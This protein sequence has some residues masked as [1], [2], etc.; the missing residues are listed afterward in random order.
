MKTASALLALG[1]SAVFS[2]IFQEPENKNVPI[3]NFNGV[4]VSNGIDVFL[5]QSQSENVRITAHPDLLKNVIVEK[6]GGN[7]K[8]RYKDNRGWSA[9]FKGQNIKVYI[10]YKTLQSIVAS[11][12]SD[13]I[14]ESTLKTDRLSIVASG[15]SDIDLSLST[16]ELKIQ[17]SGG[18][19]VNLKGTATNM[20]LSASGGS[21]IN[22]L[23]LISE[24]AKAHT[25]GGSDANIYVTKALEASASGGSDINYKGNASVRK[26]SNSKSGDV[27]RIQ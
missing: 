11:G 2:A 6:E 4:I 3:S 12:G 10:N 21:D 23:G 8:I 14:G 1:L 25:S 15:G 17:S 13:V 27:S 20:D 22:A 7:L 26:T 9:L 18:S 24:Y 19:D 16:K 5:K